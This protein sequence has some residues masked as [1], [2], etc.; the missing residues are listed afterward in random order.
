MSP[1]I[2][3]V[4]NR[5]IIPNI[6]YWV[7]GTFSRKNPIGVRAIDTMTVPYTDIATKRDSFNDMIFTLRVSKARNNPANKT[8]PFHVKRTGSH[9]KEPLDV[10]IPTILGKSLAYIRPA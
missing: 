6:A 10:Q 9:A 4:L 5:T 7:V 3:V 2:R 1:N 8:A